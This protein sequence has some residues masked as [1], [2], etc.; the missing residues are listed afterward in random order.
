MVGREPSPS[1]PSRWPYV[2]ALFLRSLGSGASSS[3]SESPSESSSLPG[4]GTSAVACARVAPARIVS[5][6]APLSLVGSSMLAILLSSTDYN[7]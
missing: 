1:R 4:C 6:L 5:A 3:S 2:G 7:S